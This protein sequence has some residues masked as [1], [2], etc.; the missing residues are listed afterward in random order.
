MRNDGNYR[1]DDTGLND[2]EAA[3]SANADSFN[4]VDDLRRDRA[5]TLKFSVATGARLDAYG[6]KEGAATSR[7]CPDSAISPEATTPRETAPA[8]LARA[9][10]H[11]SGDFSQDRH[12]KQPS[13]NMDDM[14]MK[15]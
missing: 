10:T 7:G 4:D 11:E 2:Q 8:A 1:H 15:L 5:K 14:R 6:R 3:T 13:G 12:R 9:K